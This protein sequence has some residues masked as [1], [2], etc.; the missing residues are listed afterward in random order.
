MPIVS[1]RS[2]IVLE[3]VLFLSRGGGLEVDQWS[4]NRNLSIWVDQSPLWPLNII[5]LDCDISMNKE[6][7]FMLRNIEERLYDHV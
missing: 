5:S 1:D 2:L 3:T 7:L 6:I 4:D